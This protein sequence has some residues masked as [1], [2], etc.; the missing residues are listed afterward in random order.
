MAWRISYVLSKKIVSFYKT[1]YCGTNL[2]TQNTGGPQMS[3]ARDMI[4]L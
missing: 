2:K 3:P 4:L 1:K